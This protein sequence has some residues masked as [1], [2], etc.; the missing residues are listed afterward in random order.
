VSDLAGEDRRA[1]AIAVPVAVQ[2]RRLCFETG[3]RR[4][5]GDCAPTPSGADLAQED[6]S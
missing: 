1:G 4:R 2:L 6:S 5:R 3:L